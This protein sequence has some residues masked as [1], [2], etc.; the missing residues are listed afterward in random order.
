[1][2]Q[3][4]FTFACCFV[5]M[6]S[7]YFF[8]LKWVTNTNYFHESSV[9]VPEHVKEEVKVDGVDT[10]EDRGERAEREM[11]KSDVCENKR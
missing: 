6:L 8:T 3:L 11:A 4:A 2:T 10:E 9:I 1:M 7:L 5:G